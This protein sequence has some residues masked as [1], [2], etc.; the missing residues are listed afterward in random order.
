M[1][2]KMNYKE[3]IGTYSNFNKYI[4]KKKDYFIQS[5]KQAHLRFE[6]EYGKQLQFDWKGPITIHNKNGDEFIFYIFSSTLC[7]SR[8]HIFIYS[9]FMTL[10]CV[11]KC[12]IETFKYIGGVPEECL[13]DNM[14]SIVNYS[15]NKFTKEFKAFANDMGFKVQKS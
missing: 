4:N 1:Y 13:T 2:I 11:E 15:E 5:D 7:A 3:N 10:E 9:T 14:S 6:T 8:L 12:L